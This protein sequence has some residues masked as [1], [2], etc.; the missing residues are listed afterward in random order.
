MIRP[1]ITLFGL[2]SV[3]PAWAAAEG[4]SIEPGQWKVTSSTVMNGAA[5]QPGV[6]TRCLGA[7]E[8]GDVIKTF[9]P[10]SDTINSTCAPTVFETTE[11]RMKWHMQCKGQIDID[12][13]GDFNFDSP[14]HYTATVSSK[15]WMA[16]ALMSDVKTE[17]LGERI[18]DCQQ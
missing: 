3:L 14:T 8:A 16:G 13:V 4:L 1:A 6:K 12:V 5:T 15:G 2:L 7:E 11:R 17:L 9:G 10:R 18:G